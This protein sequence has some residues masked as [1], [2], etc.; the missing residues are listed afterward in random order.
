VHRRN[1]GAVSGLARPDGHTD[2]WARCRLC[3][4]LRSVGLRGL[5]QFLDSVHSVTVRSLRPWEVP[6]GGRGL[7]LLR[8]NDLV[9]RN[10]QSRASRRIPMKIVDAKVIVCCPGRNF[11]TLK[12]TTEDGLY[13]LG[14]ATL[15][16]RE[17]AVAST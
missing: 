3:T 16:G 1:V 8:C 11:V 10:C 9:A 17:L 15:N 2:H 12:I 4:S 13:G 14:D 6:D 7:W 5:V